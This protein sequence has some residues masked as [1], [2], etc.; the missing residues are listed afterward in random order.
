MVVI[1]QVDPPAHT[2]TRDTLHATPKI[3]VPCPGPRRGCLVNSCSFMA[4]IFPNLEDVRWL[5]VLVTTMVTTYE[6]RS[7]VTSPVCS[8]EPDVRS[9]FRTRF[10]S[11][12]ALA[13]RRRVPYR[14]E[15]GLCGRVV[16][17]DRMLPQLPEPQRTA[18]VSLWEL[19]AHARR[20]HCYYSYRDCVTPAVQYTGVRREPWLQSR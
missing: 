10:R 6:P 14:L 2:H 5:L 18:V 17:G 9:R 15:P 13:Q 11:A 12:A 19:T 8:Y 16:R 3:P 1:L 20:I 7:S 4:Y